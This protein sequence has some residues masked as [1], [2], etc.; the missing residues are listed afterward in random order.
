MLTSS[1]TSALETAK[2]M[3]QGEASVQSAQR[4]P[5]SPQSQDGLPPIPVASA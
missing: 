5:A 4:Q 1:P 3:K 2:S